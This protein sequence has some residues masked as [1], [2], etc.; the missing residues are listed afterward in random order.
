MGIPLDFDLDA[1]RSTKAIKGLGAHL[2]GDGVT[3]SVASHHATAIE[4]CLFG[5]DFSGLQRESIQMYRENVDVWQAH[6]SG[7]RPGE[8]YGFR[9]HGPY[10]P[11]LGD[12]FNPAKLVLDPY[13][14]AIAGEINWDGPIFGY[15]RDADSNDQAPDTQDDA[16]FVPKSVV[17][18]RAFDWED[19]ERPLIPLQDSVIYEAHVKGLT[20]LHPEVPED[21]RG[22]YLG[23]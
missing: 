7:V 13:A 3:F 14:F 20:K 12:R 1:R 5:E 6:A 11:E 16:S 8:R 21:L 15:L 4:L 9:V 23:V 19:D 10:L 22:T 18:D 17:I 2:A